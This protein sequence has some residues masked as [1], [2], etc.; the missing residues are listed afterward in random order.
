MNRFCVLGI[1]FMVFL[2]ACTMREV[3]LAE[4]L[5]QKGD[6]DGAVAAYREAVRKDPFNQELDEKLKSVKAR[7]AEQHF[8]RGRQML[9]ERK[10]GEALQ[11][12]QI[13]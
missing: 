4:E 11:E 8:S 3:Q 7:A 2:I 9:K 10:M 12:F 13:A 1:V 6:W 5:E